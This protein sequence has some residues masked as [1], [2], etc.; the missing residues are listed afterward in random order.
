[1]SVIENCGRAFERT[2][3]PL[4]GRDRPRAVWVDLRAAGSMAIDDG[5][6]LEVVRG[7]L[8]RWLRSADGQWIG[9]VSYV[10]RC[11]DGSTYKAVDQLVPAYALRPR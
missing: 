1:M 9:L 2:G 8:Q 10:V 7:G 3:L 6:V 11:A 5:L 4:K